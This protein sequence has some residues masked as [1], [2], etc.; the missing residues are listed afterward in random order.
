MELKAG[1]ILQNGRYRIISTLGKGGFGIT[2]LA[3]HTQLRYNVC[4]KEFFPT[5]FY[6]RGEDSSALTI[7]DVDNTEIMRHFKEKF[8]KE[9]RTLIS[10][11]QRNIVRVIDSF[12][13]ND[14][15]YYVME[16]IDG[17]TLQ[18]KILRGALPEAL[19]RKYAEQVADALE[20]IHSHNTLHLDIKPQNIMVRPDDSVVVIDFGLSKHYDD[21]T[22]KETTT[23]VGA[24]SD[25][26]APMEQYIGSGIH[27]F[28][29]ETDI[30]SLGATLFAMV[31]GKRPPKANEIDKYGLPKL[32]SHLSQ[33]MRNAI[34]HSMMV[35]IN[36]RPHSIAEFRKL[37]K[38][39]KKSRWGCIIPTI[40]VGAISLILTLFLVIVVIVL[41][42]DPEPDPIPPYD[43][44]KAKELCTL[45]IDKIDNG[46]EEEGFNYI[47]EAAEM[48]YPEAQ[49][50]LGR[51]YYYGQGVTQSYGQAK[52][53]YGKAA[54]QGYEDAKKAL[55]RL[56][57]QQPSNLK[58]S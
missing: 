56:G 35:N 29:P 2:Y 4:I 21:K 50:E 33:S 17:E 53:W 14:T 16:Y 18:V 12:E 7:K 43:P 57:A 10:M 23:A 20:Y 38:P 51:C 13:E 25:G 8:L 5:T 1:A 32:P 36:M 3:E 24:Y 49:Y 55:E 11:N 34:R 39:S 46:N 28:S 15:A 48:G 9:A 27:D 47:K 44:V 58:D 40:I 54:E 41:F 26:Y 45:G 31:M 42:S 22:G 19:A 30:Y 6:R 37:F 52:Y